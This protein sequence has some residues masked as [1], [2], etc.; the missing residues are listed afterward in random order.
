MPWPAWSGLV[1]TEDDRR[2]PSGW[3]TTW[4]S[5]L[6]VGLCGLLLVVDLGPPERFWHMLIQSETVPADVQVV[7]ADVGGL[8][9]RSRAFGAFSFVSFVGVLAEDRLVRPRQVADDRADA[10]SVGVDRQWP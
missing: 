3:P 7:V 10:T 1:G 5:P 2:G 6:I 8:V 9:G 4:R